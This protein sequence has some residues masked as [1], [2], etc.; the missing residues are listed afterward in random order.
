MQQ[1]EIHSFASLP[2]GW[3]D[4]FMTWGTWRKKGWEPLL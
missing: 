2:G 4:C 1:C 3:V